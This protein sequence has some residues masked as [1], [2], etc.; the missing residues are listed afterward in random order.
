MAL[1]LII[2]AI[3]YWNTLPLGHAVAQRQ[4]DGLSCP[5]ARF[6]SRSR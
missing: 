6:A 5:G 2:A 4:S 3:I 1:N